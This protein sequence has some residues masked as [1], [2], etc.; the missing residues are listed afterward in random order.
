MRVQIRPAMQRI[1]AKPAA[2]GPEQIYRR[3][4]EQARSHFGYRHFSA[5]RIARNGAIIFG[6][7]LLTSWQLGP[8][9]V[10]GIPV[11]WDWFSTSRARK[12]GEPDK[13][14]EELVKSCLSISSSKIAKDLVSY[15]RR[16]H[17]VM[18]AEFLVRLREE[19]ETKFREVLDWVKDSEDRRAR[20][21]LDEFDHIS[22]IP[23]A[24]RS[25]LEKARLHFAY[26]SLSARRIVRNA[27]ATLL[28]IN[29][30]PFDIT[31]SAPILWW[32]GTLGLYLGGSLIADLVGAYRMKKRNNPNQLLDG[33]VHSSLGVGA[34]VIA[35]DLAS[36]DRRGLKEMGKGY[37]LRLKEA[38]GTKFVQVIALLQESRRGRSLA[39][40]FVE[41]LGTKEV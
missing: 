28:L 29:C 32:A 19:N 10:V 3:S 33:L 1:V 30:T 35:R 2:A 5:K 16:G 15:N 22:G 20:K 9:F 36:Y 31:S 23:T 26:A 12:T 24:Y 11:L 17:R 14:L 27:L 40:A 13:L 4:L 21:I 7:G 38:C 25:S 41:E 8:Q 34:N 18:A 39:A 6:I 37:L